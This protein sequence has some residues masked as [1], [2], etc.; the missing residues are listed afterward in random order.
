MWLGRQCV[1]VTWIQGQRSLRRGGHSNTFDPQNGIYE[2]TL[3]K[4]AQRQLNL[5]WNCASSFTKQQT[6]KRN[7]PINH[8]RTNSNGKSTVVGKS[9]YFGKNLYSPIYIF[10][11]MFS[12]FFII[13]PPKRRHEREQW[14]HINLLRS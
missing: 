13:S 3:K 6:I 9:Q 4:A 2:W 11:I 5:L 12:Q 1:I 10:Q 8:K 14:W 7:N